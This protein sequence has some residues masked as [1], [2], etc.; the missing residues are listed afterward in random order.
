MREKL[1]TVVLILVSYI[2]AAV[3][4]AIAVLL[5]LGAAANM[6]DWLPG[7][8]AIVLIG[9]FVPFIVALVVLQGMRQTGWLAHAIAGLTVSLVAV[10]TT[11]PGMLA[12]PLALAENWPML[13]SGAGAGLVYWLVFRTLDRM[14]PPPA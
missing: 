5:L 4:A 10:L 7:A 12:N 11:A 8:I 14:L 2:I 6:G 3:C 1:R 13:V 9:G